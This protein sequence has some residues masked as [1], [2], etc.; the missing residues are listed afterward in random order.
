[1]KLKV[2]IISKPTLKELEEELNSWLNREAYI[3]IIDIKFSESNCKIGQ[4]RV[5]NFT[6]YILMERP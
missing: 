2:H 5:M 3:K 4:K 1:M 6:A